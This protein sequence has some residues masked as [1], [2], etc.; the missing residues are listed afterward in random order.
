MDWAWAVWAVA[1]A[2]GGG[3]GVP[4]GGGVDASI[5]DTLAPLDGASP[6]GANVESGP[7]PTFT[8]TEHVT[9]STFAAMFTAAK[10]GD[11]LCLAPGNYGTSG[12]A[13][14]RRRWSFSHLMSL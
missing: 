5:E 3:G 13:G 4:D 6:E 11:V 8:C 10:G 2:C 12:K 7:P 9:T 1:I 14:R